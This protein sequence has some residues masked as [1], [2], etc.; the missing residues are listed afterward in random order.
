MSK[1]T[2]LVTG[3]AGFIG[4]HVVDAFIQKG[5]DVIVV[6]DLSSG[7]SDYV[8]E[9]AVFYEMDVRSPQLESV[10]EAHKPDV[11]SHHAAQIDVR[12]S[13]EDP[14]Y[15]A[16]VNI[17]GALNLLEMS[18]KY[19]VRKFV[20]ASTGGAIYGSPASLPADENCVPKPESPYG[21][22][23][24]CVEQYIHLYN[25]IHKINF[26]ILRYPN[27]YGPRQSAHGEAGVC[28]IF[29]G[30]MLAGKTPVLYGKGDAF[31]D[32]VFVDDIAHANVLA[33]NKAPGE[34]I[35]LGSGVGIT[36]KQL[37]EIIKKLT[38]FS[39]KAVL[40][41]LRPGEVKGIYITGERAAKMLG[42]KPS[43]SL[44]EG[45]RRTVAFVREQ[46]MSATCGEE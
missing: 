29:A 31:R 32:Y 8:H 10:F 14:V 13:V 43:V 30:L 3:G 21:T 34:T 35:N 16:D 18:V 5:H 46:Q 12:K 4:S 38:G 39:G 1:H 33:L 23:K 36:V 40:K 6:D 44:E 20:F 9:A 15:D 7:N 26:T 24:L 27:V 19:G 41:P 42:W 17:R 2:I 25:R 28:S 37:Y 22:S 11:I 45:L